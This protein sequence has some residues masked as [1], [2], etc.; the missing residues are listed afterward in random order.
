MR[1]IQVD[2][3]YCGPKYKCATCDATGTTCLSC[4]DPGRLLANNCE[5]ALSPGV[6]SQTCPSCDNYLYNQLTCSFDL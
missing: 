2:Y 4:S 5:C 6:N 3:Y 1:E